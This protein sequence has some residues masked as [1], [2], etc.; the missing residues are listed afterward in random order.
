MRICDTHRDNS[1]KSESVETSNDSSNKLL[2]QQIQCTSIQTVFCWIG[3]DIW[4]EGS[5]FDEKSH[6][7]KTKQFLRNL[8][9]E[10]STCNNNFH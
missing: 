10:K 9:C 5:F 7:Y 3:S 1:G 4:E 2:Y 6:F 8:D